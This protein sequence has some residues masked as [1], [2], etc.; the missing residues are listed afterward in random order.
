MRRIIFIV[1]SC[2]YLMGCNDK[3]ASDLDVD[4]EI[5]LEVSIEHINSNTDVAKNYKVTAFTIKLYE[6]QVNRL[7][8]LQ[9]NRH[10]EVKN[11]GEFIAVINGNEFD[12]SEYYTSSSNLISDAS[13]KYLLELKDYTDDIK[14]L[15]ISFTF[16]GGTFTA[17]VELP[18]SLSVVNQVDTLV[19]YNPLVDGIFIEWQNLLLPAKLYTSKLL[20]L[21]DTTLNCNSESITKALTEEDT[22][23]TLDVND[24]LFDC[25]DGTQTVE[26]VQSKIDI[27]QDYVELETTTQGFE[28]VSI[29]L[30][31]MY[32]W[33]KEDVL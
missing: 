15:S 14:E 20:E 21:S 4:S 23:L 16:E 33:L 9:A 19:D 22:S 6:D 29:T 24:Y 25:Y 17:D 7:K 3:D 28:D 8:V 5:R 2:I 31:Q 26:K 27:L 12:L 18:D 32:I 10:I 13:G 11:T 1:L 30:S